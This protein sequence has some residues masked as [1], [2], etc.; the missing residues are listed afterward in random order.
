MEYDDITYTVM[1][2]KKQD[3][4]TAKYLLVLFIELMSFILCV[5]C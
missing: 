1:P 2:V 3:V 5:H 4:V